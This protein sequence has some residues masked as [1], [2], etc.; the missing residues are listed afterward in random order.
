MAVTTVCSVDVCDR[1]AQHRGWCGAHY[2]RWW[3]HG[4]PEWRPPT[5][6]KPLCSVA[7]CDRPARAL[8]FCSTHYRRQNVTGTTADLRP[9]VAERFW[10]K[11]ERMP[12]GCWRWTDDIKPSGYGQMSVDGRLIYAHRLAYELLVGPIP[13]GLTIDHLCR[14]RACVNPSHLEPVTIGENVLRSDSFTAVNARKTHCLRGHAFDETNTVV[15]SQGY[16]DCLTCRVI[17]NERGRA[18]R[19]DRS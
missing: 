10:A 14:V 3:K 19:K 9:K 5:I 15:T 2:Q 8:G 7:A 12:G 16:R 18:N 13:E 1:P 17:R 6:S 4:D 11:F